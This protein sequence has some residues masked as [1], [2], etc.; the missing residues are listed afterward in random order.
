MTEDF[1]S[2]ALLIWIESMHYHLQLFDHVQQIVI[3]VLQIEK[4]AFLCFCNRA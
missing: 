1:D 2:C 3:P 4:M